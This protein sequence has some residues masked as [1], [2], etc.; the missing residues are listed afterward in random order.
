M[1]DAFTPNLNLTKP[2]VGASADT[3]GTKQND[4]F[5]KIDA[6]FNSDGSGTSV[7]VNVGTG[8]TA[9]VAGTLSL[10]GT[11]TAATGSVANFLLGTLNVVASRFSVKDTVDNTKVGKFDASLITTG[12]TRTLKFPNADGTMATDAS[13]TSGIVAR[14]PAGTVLKGYYSSLPAGFVWVNGQTIGNAGSGAQQRANA[15]CL[16]LY[17]ILWNLGYAVTGG[18]GASAAADWAALKPI[19]TPDHCGRV[20]APPD[21]LG[22]ITSKARLNT[23]LASTAIGA[24]GGEQQ[25]A[26]TGAEGPTHTHTITDPGHSHTGSFT[27]GTAGSGGGSG[28]PVISTNVNTGTATTSI[29]INNAGSGTAHNN[30][31]PTVIV[32]EII[33]L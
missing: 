25:H 15:D 1:P 27:T 29:T 16:T 4:A 24:T 13:V 14:V 12:T 23:A 22:G 2:E 10:L 11:L 31:Q 30:V 7:G 18:A 21:N 33:A 19:A 8:N 28:I 9:K 32:P 6:V 5:D 3:W 17:T 26:L 20:S